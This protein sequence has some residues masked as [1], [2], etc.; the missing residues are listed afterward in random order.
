M[1]IDPDQIFSYHN[2]SSAQIERTNKIRSA[3][4]ETAEVILQNAPECP[5]QTLAIRYLEMA[6]FFSNAAIARNSL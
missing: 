4:R 3:C 5:E 6:M 2:L 1:P